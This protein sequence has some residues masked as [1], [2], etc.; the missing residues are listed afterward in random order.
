MV[1]DANARGR[2][3]VQKAQV[4]LS[5]LER[6]GVRM[7]GNAFS[8]VLFAK[9]ELGPA[10]LRGG[11]P[12]SGPDG[13]A[14]RAALMKL[15]Y[16]PQD[17]AALL[18]PEDVEL[19]RRTVAVLDPHTLVACDQTAANAVREAF[20]SDLVELSDLSDAMLEVGRP[21]MVLGMRVLALDGFEAALSSS[22]QKQRMWAYLKRIPPLGEPY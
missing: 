4:E 13:Q 7:A 22:R 12:L 3:Y 20:A 17:W 10:E 18:V 5:E 9:G 19:L 11:E 16:E 15:G 2:A 14:L 6:R 21:V 8:G 1:W